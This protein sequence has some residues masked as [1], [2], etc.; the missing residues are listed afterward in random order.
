MTSETDPRLSLSIWCAAGRHRDAPGER[1]PYDTKRAPDYCSCQCHVV[2]RE[3]ERQ[4]DTDRAL[5]VAPESAHVA[6]DIAHAVEQWIG[7]R[8]AE[9]FP[10]ALT[11]DVDP[12]LAGRLDE[13]VRAYVASWVWD[14]VPAPL[15][16]PE[17]VA[18]LVEAR[19]ALHVADEWVQTH[20]SDRIV[21]DDVSAALDTVQ[22]ALKRSNLTDDDLPRP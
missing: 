8:L 22:D 13:A 20:E 14:N 5:A 3:H 21:R 10:H 17:A 7:E 19:N 2:E 11:G 1:C 6:D 12:Y 9:A 15:T 18:A 4:S 16:L